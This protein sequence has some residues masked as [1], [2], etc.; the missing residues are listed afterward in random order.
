ILYT[1][2]VKNNNG[3]YSIE[4]NDEIDE[5]FSEIEFNQHIVLLQ[6]W[7][8]NETKIVNHNNYYIKFKYIVIQIIIPKETYNYLIETYDYYYYK[9]SGYI[10]N[11]NN[12]KLYIIDNET[13]LSKALKEENGMFKYNKI[14][15]RKIYMLS[16]EF[17]KLQENIHENL[18]VINESLSSE[19]E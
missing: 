6:D 3:K 13:T 10:F 11:L 17:I 19:N 8:T 9:P 18:D 5:D 12:D 1:I 7:I 4:K 15:K 2:F 16:E 14:D